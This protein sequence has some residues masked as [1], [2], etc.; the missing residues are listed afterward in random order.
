MLPGR[1]IVTIAR[2]AELLR[3]SKPTAAKTVAILEAAQ[4]LKEKTGKVRD[5][6]YGY[7]A[8]LAVL[9]ADTESL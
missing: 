9:C 6:A 8:Y 7:G 2:V 1:P 4:I 3:V 5:R